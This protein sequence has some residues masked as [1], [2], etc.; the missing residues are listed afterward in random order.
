M[1]D[2]IEITKSGKLFILKIKKGCACSVR[3]IVLSQEEFEELKQQ[4]AQQG[5]DPDCPNC[6]GTGGVLP[7]G[8][9]GLCWNWR[10]NEVWE[11]H[12]NS[13]VREQ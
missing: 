7:N 8:A 1:S 12:V 10:G 9:C 4:I 13:G 2:K 11:H 5:P 6:D 3:T